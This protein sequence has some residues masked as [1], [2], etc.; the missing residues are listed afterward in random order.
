MTLFKAIP[1]ILNVVMISFLF[2]LVF[3]II[4]VNFL[5]GKFYYCDTSNIED[6]QGFD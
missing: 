2:F 3:G 6:N 5:K 1:N 4:G